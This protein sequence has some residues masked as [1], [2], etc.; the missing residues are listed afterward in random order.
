[1]LNLETT[2]PFGDAR[3]RRLEEIVVE[4]SARTT[5]AADMSSTVFDAMIRRMAM[6]QLVEEELRRRVR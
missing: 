1:M 5:R 3:S 2:H 4:I 6:R